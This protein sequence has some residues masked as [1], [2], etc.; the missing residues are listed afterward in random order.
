M[1]QRPEQPPE[2][3]LIEDAAGNLDL[4]IRE[5]ARRAGLSYGRW[6]Q[7]VKGYQNVSPG[8]YAQV[9][10]APAKT[11]ARMAAVVGVAPEQMETEGQRPDVA[12]VMRRN[13]RARVA[14]PLTVVPGL[15]I[16]LEL[17]PDDIIAEMSPAMR[18]ATEAHISGLASVYR[19]AN[20]LGP[21]APGERIFPGSPRE[22]TRWDRLVQAG[23]I[24]KPGKGYSAEEMVVMIAQGRAYDDQYQAATGRSSRARDALTSV[25]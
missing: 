19:L 2:G 24:E 5:A 18:A 7:I 9:R 25:T 20:I 15:P 12:E 1:D 13:A 22:A 4:S 8:V 11:V 23:Y 16:S 10:N 14:P 17:G 3:K 21:D 6:R